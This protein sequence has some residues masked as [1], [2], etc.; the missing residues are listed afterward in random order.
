MRA[1]PTSGRGRLNFRSYL[2]IA[3]H[4]ALRVK[5]SIRNCFVNYISYIIILTLKVTESCDYFI[6]DISM[7][8]HV[9]S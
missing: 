8:Q 7:Q 3:F 4:N 9:P 6:N 5:A 1:F 2:I